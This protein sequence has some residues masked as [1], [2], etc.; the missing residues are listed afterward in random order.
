MKGA[1]SGSDSRESIMS[2]EDCEELD[3]RAASTIRLCLAKNVLANVGKFPSAKQLWKRLENLYQTKSISNHLYL[4]E[5]FHTL[6]MIEGTKL[7]DH[8][9]VLNGIVTELKAIRVKI[10]DKDKALRL[11]WSLPTSYKHLLPTLIYG[12]E[13]VDFEEVTS[14]LLSEERRLSGGSNE[15]VDDWALIVGNWKK[16]NSKK[17]IVYWVC[18]QSGHLKKDCQKAN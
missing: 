16:N 10:E 6:R 12:K 17:K 5:R 7:S 4:Q 9:S 2:D 8:F 18:G 15:A 13:T 1:T 11:L 3:E 14:T